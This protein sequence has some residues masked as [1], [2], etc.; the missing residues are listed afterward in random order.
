MIFLATIV[1]GSAF[2]PLGTL[3]PLRPDQ[4][5]ILGFP[6]PTEGLPSCALGL[7]FSPD[8]KT[9]TAFDNAF[10]G[11]WDTS[12]GAEI[13][14]GQGTPVRSI[15][16]SEAGLL[17]L[18]GTPGTSECL[19]SNAVTGEKQG[20]FVMPPSTLPGGADAR[21]SIRYPS[22]MLANGKQSTAYVGPL[23]I[24]PVSARAACVVV[25]PQARVQ[26][27]FSEGVWIFLSQDG[28][29][30]QRLSP[31]K[32]STPAR[33]PDR[34]STGDP[35]SIRD[36]V[37]SPNG[38]QLAAVSFSGTIVVWNCADGKVLHTLAGET[39]QDLSWPIRLLHEGHSATDP[40][41]A[42]LLWVDGA[43]SLL[44]LAPRPELDAPGI[45]RVVRWTLSSSTPRTL[46][47]IG[48]KLGVSVPAQLATARSSA[49]EAGSGVPQARFV[50]C[51]LDGSRAIV[52]LE[53][54]KP[55]YQNYNNTRPG[56]EVVDL[57][58]GRAIGV[59]CVPPT[60]FVS[61]IAVTPDS[62]RVAL[63]LKHG[64][65]VV[66]PMADLDEFAA[67]Q[68]SLVEIGSTR[69]V[70]DKRIAGQL[71]VSAPPARAPLNVNA[72][73]MSEFELTGSG[74]YVKSDLGAVEQFHIPREHV[75]SP[76]S[77]LI[78]GCAIV[79]AD[80]CP[81]LSYKKSIAEFKAAGLRPDPREQSAEAA[82]KPFLDGRR[83]ALNLDFVDEPVSLPGGPCHVY[84]A[85]IDEK[86]AQ[87]S[88]ALHWSEMH[89]VVEGDLR[90]V[91]I[92]VLYPREKEAELH[93]PLRAMLLGMQQR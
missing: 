76:R 71:K 63:S 88:D 24:S 45:R 64:S 85:S 35:L 70:G 75:P 38:K 40:N 32:A 43:E 91:R 42:Q 57:R 61:S 51:S 12:T 46:E 52:A 84:T 30:L 58:Q 27:A 17:A 36:L 50:V 20:A 26:A 31:P 10:L 82:F 93:D 69:P 68:R 41:S 56:L 90:D 66:I 86:K 81:H 22:Y 78:A 53:E 2:L 11:S 16:R 7:Q 87:V 1:L 54:S 55:N 48:A 29:V 72:G 77:V 3:G 62:S 15:S 6:A 92:C 9:L 5:L 13:Y 37:F 49:E 83:R 23:A 14:C 25:L 18:V 80:V 73:Q 4:T 44:T 8:G 39:P 60:D 19:L 67:H 33:T 79:T 21:K 59:I 47:W 34:S 28:K 65:I 74:I 89:A